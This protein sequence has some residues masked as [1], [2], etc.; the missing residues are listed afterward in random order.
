LLSFIAL[1][2]INLGILN[3]LPIPMLD[4][5]HLMFYAIEAL[6]MRKMPQLFY[7]VAMRLGFAVI[8]FMMMV[9]VLNDLRFLAS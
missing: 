1:L 4:G 9:A 3:L 5:G 2:S 8:I 6:F 7:E